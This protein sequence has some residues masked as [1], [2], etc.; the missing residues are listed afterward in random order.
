MIFGGSMKT[1]SFFRTAVLVPSLGVMGFASYGQSIAM[2][3]GH[4]I[5]ICADSTVTTWGWNLSGQLGKGYYTLTGDCQCFTYAAPVGYLDSVVAVVAGNYHTVVLRRDGTVRNWGLGASGQMG[6]GFYPGGTCTCATLPVQPVDLPPIRKIAAG[7]DH[8]LAIAADS[9]VW[10]WGDNSKG[11][12]GDGTGFA[13]PSPAHVVGLDHVVAIGAGERHSL[14]V[15]SDGTVWA[16]GENDEGQLGDTTHTDRN[17]PVRVYGLTDVVA[18]AGGWKHSVALKSDGTVWGWGINNFDQLQNTFLADTAAPVQIPIIGDVRAI[19]SGWYHMV[20]LKNDSTVWSWGSGFYGQMGDGT[21]DNF[22]HEPRQAN[23]LTGVVEISAKRN[24]TLVALSDST[25][26][27]WGYNYYGQLCDNT[28]LD[29]NTPT[30]TFNVCPAAISLGDLEISRSAQLLVAPNPF[31]DR[32]TIKGGNAS[33]YRIIS[34]SGETVQ[35]GRVITDAIDV[36]TLVPGCYVLEL[37]GPNAAVG[38]TRILKL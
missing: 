2:G 1:I 32:L 14:A 31:E 27:G 29:K 16:W 12:L 11:Q 26:R 25:V 10:A 35:S 8:T 33:N 24:A 36:Q 17:T 15:K 3:G 20:A 5:A 6:Y 13:T 18:V 4:G 22:A 23:G 28:R 37:I 38:R 34:L 9:T 19:A 7:S 21:N 30:P